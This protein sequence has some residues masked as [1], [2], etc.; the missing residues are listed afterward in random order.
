MIKL[1][2]LTVIPSPYQR[3]LFSAIN[4]SENICADVTYYSYG[5][6]NRVW[7]RPELNEFEEVLAGR[8]VLSVD[9]STNWNPGVLLQ[10]R[11]S[12]ADLFVVSDYSAP[13]AQMAMRYLAFTGRPFVFWGE[14]PGF[15]KRGPVGNWL[16][17]R[18]Q[19]PLG[20]SKG[21]AAIGENAVAAYRNLFPGKKVFNIPYFCDLTPFRN[22]ALSRGQKSSD[23]FDLLYSGQLIERKGVDLLLRAFVKEALKD[24]RLRLHL[25][26]E[27]PQK[28]HYR[29]MV[30]PQIADRVSFHG[31]IA[32]DDLPV[33][34]AQADAFCLPSR[35]DGWGVVVNEALGAGLPIIVSDAVGAGK[36][37]VAHGRN[38]FVFPADNE[39]ALCDAIAS[40]A[41]SAELQSSMA[42]ASQERAKD[43]G[44]TEGVRRWE[45]AAKILLA[46]GGQEHRPSPRKL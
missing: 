28:D 17:R 41:S 37:L 5:A 32:P 14:I 38:G 43:W 19:A 40:L 25:L 26:G 9:G 29:A 46:G 18:L 12:S 21:I 3:Q 16:R 24:R 35:H 39:N 6:S 8:R 30:P 15:S 23:S 42:R 22:A 13:T 36:D 33:F 10:L 20:A 2:F 34:F 44:L 45:D 31:H 7:Q 11:R 4:T 1:H 27:G